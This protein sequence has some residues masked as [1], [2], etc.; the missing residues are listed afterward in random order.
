MGQ[1][2]RVDDEREVNLEVKPERGPCAK[3]TGD[4]TYDLVHV[5]TSQ[6][7]FVFRDANENKNKLNYTTKLNQ[8]WFVPT[9]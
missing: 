5:R 8:N 7:R 4:E 2:S 3:R 1:E 6:T 9:V